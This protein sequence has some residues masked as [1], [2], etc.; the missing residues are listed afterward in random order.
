[1][2]YGSAQHP[3]NAVLTLKNDKIVSKVV[4]E[5]NTQEKYENPDRR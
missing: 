1:M 4:K 2:D 3:S 5:S